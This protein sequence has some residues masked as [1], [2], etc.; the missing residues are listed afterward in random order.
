LRIPL[1]DSFSEREPACASQAAKGKPLMMHKRLKGSHG[2]RSQAALVN[3]LQIMQCLAR[4][5]L[6]FYLENIKITTRWKT[7]SA[8]TESTDLIS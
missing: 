3:L 2:S 4:C 1:A 7:I 5:T 8:H 6:K